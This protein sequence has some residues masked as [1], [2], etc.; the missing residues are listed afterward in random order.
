VRIPEHRLRARLRI[1]EF[2]V[3]CIA[4]VAHGRAAAILRRRGRGQHIEDRHLRRL[5]ALADRWR[6][7]AV[8]GCHLHQGSVL[9]KRHGH[10]PCALDHAARPHRNQSVR[11]DLARLG[12][13]FLYALRR[14]AFGDPG[15]DAGNPSAGQRP[16]PLRQVGALVYAA[17]AHDQRA[18]CA[19]ALQFHGQ[20]GQ[21]VGSRM[22]PQRIGACVEGVGDGFA[23]VHVEPVGK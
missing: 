8:N 13:S 15:V 17:P 12:C 7:V 11:P 20:R 5:E 4:P 6:V 16:D 2:E 19:G 10:H 14:R 23:L 1:E 21:R 9:A 22:D 3:V 18:R